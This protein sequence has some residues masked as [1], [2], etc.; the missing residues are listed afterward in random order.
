MCKRIWTYVWSYVCVG[1]RQTSEVIPRES[2]IFLKPFYFISLET[3]GQANIPGQKASGIHLF[4]HLQSQDYKQ[5]PSCLVSYKGF[6]E[7]NS[8]PHSSMAV[9]LPTEQFPQPSMKPVYKDRR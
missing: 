8:G 2:F 3:E 6:G 9:S 1:H 4:P 5:M 7:L